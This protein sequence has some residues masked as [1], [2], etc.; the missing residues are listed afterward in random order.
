VQIG[1][2]VDAGLVT[3]T[4]EVTDRNFSARAALVARDVPGV[5]AVNNEL[6]YLSG[7]AVTLPQRPGPRRIRPWLGE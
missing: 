2:R 5:R 3:L 1:V 7:P 4:G 6:A